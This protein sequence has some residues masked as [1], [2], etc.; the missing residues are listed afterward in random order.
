METLPMLVVRCACGA[1]FKAPVS[2]AGK[3]TTCKQCGKRIRVPGGAAGATGE[4]TIGRR[5]AAASKPAASDAAARIVVVCSC[6][7]RMAAPAAMAGRNTRCKACGARVVIAPELPDAGTASVAAGMSTSATDGADGDDGLLLEF[8]DAAQFAPAVA[9]AATDDSVHPAPLNAGSA[10]KPN[11]T[12][13]SCGQTLPAKAKICVGCGI[14]LKTGRS[15]LTTQEENIDEIYQGAEQAIRV[16]S[17]LIWFSTPIIP[18]ASDAWG[19]HKPWVARGLLVVTVLISV[20]FTLVEVNGYPSMR[21]YKQHMLWPNQPGP[22]DP[23]YLAL[24]A[25]LSN[26]GDAQAL[27]A[28]VA[29]MAQQKR[30]RQQREAADEA[31]DETES[32]PTAEELIAD[33]PPETRDQLESA[34]G[35]L[36]RMGSRMSAYTE[37][38]DLTRAAHAA[39]TPRQQ[40]IGRFSAHQLISHAF[41]HAGFIHLIGNMLFLIVFCGRIN[42]LLGQTWT[43]CLYLLFAVA[44]GWAHMLSVAGL[45]PRPMVGASGALMGMAGM[46]LVMFP[47]NHIHVA[48]WIRPVFVFYPRLFLKMYTM[49]GFWFVLLFIGFD[50]WATWKGGD[51]G[52]AHW[53]HLGGFI[54]GV[55][56]ALTLLVT[57]LANARGADILSMMLGQRA[58]AIV[59]RPGGDSGAER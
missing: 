39:L 6:G 56:A 38:S 9:G 26:M 43:L 52:V 45:S 1:K 3:R 35:E 27:D 28:E 34:F 17:W 42:A 5:A 53:A 10:A 55:V 24:L 21:D 22:I 14:N 50:V 48:A 49:R 4:L 37:D 58:W 36:L 54:A 46:F 33:L 12:C 47:V 2:A 8:A 25:S 57:R 32:E 29:K 19:K 11:Q 20:W 13:P 41:L 59:G 30:E 44:A 15:L 23:E 31:G 7:K 18:I 40:F 51:G 16:A